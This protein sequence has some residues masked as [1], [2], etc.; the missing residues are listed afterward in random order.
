V[1]AELTSYNG[2]P[3]AI[4]KE[5]LTTEADSNTVIGELKDNGDF[6]F[7]FTKP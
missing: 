6:G 3:E 5:I 7:V 4:I 1:R 2:R